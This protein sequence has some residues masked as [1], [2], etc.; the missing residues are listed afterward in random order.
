LARCC[1][2]HPCC[3]NARCVGVSASGL[4]AVRQVDN[5]SPGLGGRAP[6]P[7]G[8]SRRLGRGF[9]QVLARGLIPPPTSP[10]GPGLTGGGGGSGRLGRAF[11]PAR[12]SSSAWAQCRSAPPS[13]RP[14]RS[15]IEGIASAV[16]QTTLRANVS[17]TGITPPSCLGPG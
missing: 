11:L 6:V 5:A 10:P 2:R 12:S 16:T 4:F 14:S 1:R 13:G 8:G 3:L 7:F 17:G 9:G 15:Q